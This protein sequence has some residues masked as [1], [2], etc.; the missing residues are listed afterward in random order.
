MH[1]VPAEAIWPTLEWQDWCATADT[2]H[3]MTQIVGKTRLMLTPLQNHWWN[4]TLYVSVRGLRTGAMPLPGG[5]TL[6]IEF[7]FHRHVLEFSLNSGQRASLPLG[8]QPVAAFFASYQRILTGLGIAVRIDP[9]PVE[10]ATPIRFDLDTTHQSYEHAAVERF[11]AVLTRMDELFKRFSTGF[12]G[13]ISPVHFFWG[14]FD[15]AVTRF[16]GRRAPARAGADKVQAEAYSYECISAG[17]WPGNGG[18]GRAAL[19][20]YAAPVPPGLPGRVIRAPGHFDTA[21]GEFLLDYEHVRKAP[22][23]AEQVLNFL[24]DAYAA[25]ADEAHWDRAQLEREGATLPGHR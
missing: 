3:M 10:V 19:Y 12:L 9:M 17:F 16:N 7:D 23:P 18:Y 11:F 1:A 4:V 8:P 15:L 24:E 2:L 25:C 6:E 20:C 14:S 22:A 5:R 13:K 21:L